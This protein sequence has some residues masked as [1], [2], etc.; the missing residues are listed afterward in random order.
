VPK[1]LPCPPPITGAVPLI[2]R[3]SSTKIA[4]SF[5]ESYSIEIFATLISLPALKIIAPYGELLSG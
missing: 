2:E 5:S 1:S 4:R 3:G